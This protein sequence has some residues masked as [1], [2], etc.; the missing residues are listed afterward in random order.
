MGKTRL[1]L[2]RFATRTCSIERASEKEREREKARVRERERERKREG[3]GGMEGDRD[4]ENENQTGTTEA[5]EEVKITHFATSSSQT[6]VLIGKA[7][8]FARSCI[9]GSTP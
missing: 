8:H 6:S 2:Q 5:N 9:P 1:R 3:E 7:M 4:R